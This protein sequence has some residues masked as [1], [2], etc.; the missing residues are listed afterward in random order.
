MDNFLLEKSLKNTTKYQTKLE[1][2]VIRSLRYSLPKSSKTGHLIFQ[3]F[4]VTLLQI[5]K[6]S[7]VLFMIL[8]L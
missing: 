4:L 8:I 7:L 3:R 1:Q 2:L 5:T 6:D